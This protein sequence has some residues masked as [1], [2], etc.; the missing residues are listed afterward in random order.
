[1]GVAVSLQEPRPAPPIE[2]RG[3]SLDVLSFNMQHRDRPAELDVVVEYLETDLDRLPDFLLC[4]E[5]V[6]RRSRREGGPDTAAVLADALGYYSQGTKRMADREGVAIVSRYPFD[7]YEHLHLASKTMI[8]LLG[9]RRVAVMGEFHVPQM[10]HVRVVNV[11][12]AYLFFE[13]HVRRK[14][15]QETLEWIAQRER[16]VPADITIL[17]GDFNI[18]PHWKEFAPLRDPRITAPLV[19]RDANTADPTWGAPGDPHKRTDYIFVA[20]AADGAGPGVEFLR[21]TLL[22]RDGLWHRD[23]SRRFWISDHLVVLH[24]YAVSSGQW[25]VVS[26]QG[27]EEPMSDGR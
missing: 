4:Q 14:Q 3:P 15:L 9:R 12:F 6:F 2:H 25:L 5:V 18:A 8:P 24:E 13:H 11:H 17:G 23:G 22:F 7:H 21:E 16:E 19:Y 27:R 20:G 1:M 26:G 10:G